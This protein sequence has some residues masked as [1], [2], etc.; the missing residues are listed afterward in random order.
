MA[1]C[2]FVYNIHIIC[3]KK[4]YCYDNHDAC[5]HKHCF[6]IARA[7]HRT[8]KA[9]NV[10][11]RKRTIDEK[12][13]PTCD[14]KHTDKQLRNELVGPTYRIAYALQIQIAYIGAVYL[15]V[16]MCVCVCGCV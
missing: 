8:A 5:A 13:K 15:N 10:R 14:H 7:C 9:I 11:T 16:Y 4:V 2:I 3:T 6:Y 1:V 12:P